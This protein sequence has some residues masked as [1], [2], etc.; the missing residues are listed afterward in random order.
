MP[1]LLPAL[2][3]AV[4]V[5]VALSLTATALL[6]PTAPQPAASVRQEAA[7]SPEDL[8]LLRRE[9][10]DLRAQV[11]DLEQ[12]LAVARRQPAAPAPAPAVDQAAPAPAQASPASAAEREVFREQVAQV[13]TE[14]EEAEE[15]ERRAKEARESNEEYDRIEETLDA[16]L[17][18]LQTSLGL[19]AK[20]AG[21]LGSLLAVQNERNR[22]MTR[23]WSEGEP[24]EELDARFQEYRASHRR[25]VVALLGPDQLKTYRR[26]LRENHLGGRFSFFVGPWEDWSGSR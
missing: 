10:V 26:M 4:L 20:Q 12:R 24:K 1:R 25:E 14:L 16:R 21:D 18:S 11:D 13:L 19:T 22:E 3:I 7:V 15:Q 9:V 2:C 23:L 8:D 5:S 17:A 6:D